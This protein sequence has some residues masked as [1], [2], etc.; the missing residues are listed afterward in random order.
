MDQ[1]HEP[2]FLWDLKAERCNAPKE[3]EVAHGRGCVAKTSSAEIL[4][5]WDPRALKRM[6]GPGAFQGTEAAR[7]HTAHAQRH[8]LVSLREQRKGQMEPKEAIEGVFGIFRF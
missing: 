5:Q 8:G 2:G 1:R 3:K 4:A 7:G 6:A